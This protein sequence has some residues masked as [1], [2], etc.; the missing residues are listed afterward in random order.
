MDI[1]GLSTTN[2]SSRSVMGASC[3]ETSLGSA[4]ISLHL[5]GDI[6]VDIMH[7]APALE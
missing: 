2:V 3:K 5:K 7:N 1:L 4:L 6:P